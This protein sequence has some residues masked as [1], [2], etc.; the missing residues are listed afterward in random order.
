MILT[1]ATFDAV[2]VS[3]RFAAKQAL[4]AVTMSEMS[5]SKRIT[6]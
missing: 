2:I 4:L 3:R 5:R 6:L 1:R